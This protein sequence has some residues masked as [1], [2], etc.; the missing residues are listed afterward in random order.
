MS[1]LWNNGYYFNDSKYT[2]TYFKIIN[3]SRNQSRIR[4]KD[5]YYESHH[6]IPY[7]IEKNNETV[8]L[9]AKEHF[10]CHLLL[11]K[12]CLNIR[13]H[14]RMLNAFQMMSNTRNIGRC[15]SA[16]YSKLKKEIAQAKS[17]L[18]SGEENPFYGQSHSLE[19]REKMKA[20]KKLLDLTGNKNPN[21]GKRH[22]PEIR[23][24]ISIA[25]QNPSEESRKRISDAA[26]NRIPA[27][28]ETRA[29]ISAA[30]IGRIFSESTIDLIRISKLGSNNPNYGK[31]YT[32]EEKLTMSIKYNSLKDSLLITK[33]KMTY[34]PVVKEYKDFTPENVLLAKI[35]GII[36]KRAMGYLKVVEILKL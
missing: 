5:T 35:K 20:Q 21:Y 31:V 34:D 36:C 25:K 18:N 11:T 17:I 15:T 7:S 1:F 19:V 13:H 33:A 8:L 22:S 2:H 16:I 4:N 24:L 3:K 28:A 29:K 23:K 27:S 9:T 10:I 32:P 6:V 14:Y 26:R 12:M 30:G